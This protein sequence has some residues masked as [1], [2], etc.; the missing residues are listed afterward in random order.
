MMGCVESLLAVHM[1]LESLGK[2]RVGNRRR[3]SPSASRPSPETEPS[4]SSRL[5]NDGAPEKG[6]APEI[7]KRHVGN[8]KGA[9]EFLGESG[10]M[11]CVQRL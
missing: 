4:S 10:G 8:R 6:G 7:A 11:A 9:T 3:G 1:R 5:R 2:E